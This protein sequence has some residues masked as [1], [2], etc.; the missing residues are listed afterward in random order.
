MRFRPFLIIATAALGFAAIPAE[1]T[2]SVRALLNARKFPDAEAAANAL[3]K[4]HPQE[5][6]AHAL[7]GQVRT[8]QGE[9]EAGAKSLEK[10]CELA[11][12][13]GE[14]QRLL[15]DAYGTAAQKAGLLSKMSL[16][17]KSFAAYEKAVELEPTNVAARQSL[18]LVYYQAPS[19]M[20]GGIDKA[21]AQ[22]AEIKK[23]DATRGRV[24]YAT[25]YTSEKKY[26]EAFAEL[27]DVIK[28][29]PGNYPALFQFGRLTALSGERVDRGVAALQQ[30]LTLPPPPNSPGH[31]A[32][33]WRL[34][35]LWEKK[36]DKKAARAEYEAA[37]KVT[38]GYSQAVEALKKL[39]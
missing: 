7:L 32:A 18:M 11:P 4:A 39:E 5:A 23:L 10:A 21:Y 24:A 22:A 13:N 16:G 17:K 28:A 38:P 15:G 26:A 30:C 27:E 12:K 34:G 31:D 20:G 8:A 3:V 33:H 19:M 1:K 35:M 29:S 37:L 36:G 9:G 6:E 14:Y 2:D 25:L